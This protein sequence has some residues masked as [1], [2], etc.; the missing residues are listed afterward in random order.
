[1][2]HLEFYDWPKVNEGGIPL[3]IRILLDS[4]AAIQVSKSEEGK[5]KARWL[6]L[7]WHRVADEKDKI[8]FAK[9]DQQKAD[10]LTKPPKSEGIRGVFGIFGVEPLVSMQKQGLKP[11]I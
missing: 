6:A 3:K 8:F 2:G 4:T 11:K 9:T 5:P 1:M 10:I 7:R